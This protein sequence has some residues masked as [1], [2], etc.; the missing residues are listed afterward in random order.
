MVTSPLENVAAPPFAIESRLTTVPPCPVR[1]F[2]DD[3]ASLPASKYRLPL[4]DD[5]ELLKIWK[6]ASPGDPL[7]P[8]VNVPNRSAFPGTP[9][10]SVLG[11]AF[12]VSVPAVPPDTTTDVPTH[13]LLSSCAPSPM[14]E[15][16]SFG[17]SSGHPVVPLWSGPH[18]RLPSAAKPIILSLPLHSSA[19]PVPFTPPSALAVKAESVV[20][21]SL[22]CFPSSKSEFRL[23]TTPVSLIPV[24]FGVL[25]EVPA[26]SVR[27][28]CV[29]SPMSERLSFGGR[30][31]QLTP[32][33]PVWSVPHVSACVVELYSSLSPLPEHPL[34]PVVGKDHH[35]AGPLLPP[36]FPSSLSPLPAELPSHPRSS[37]APLPASGARPAAGVALSAVDGTRLAAVVST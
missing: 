11:L 1:K 30:N 17:G 35:E 10:S 2:T 6:L 28:R 27:S 23:L 3:A 24:I 33:P 19:L 5:A 29:R 9:M 16:L 25:I 26:Y 4:N 7:V 31:G 20:R 21:N 22:P 36:V 15:R 34:L 12:I 37:T 32:P 13:T 14:S 8:A 18:C